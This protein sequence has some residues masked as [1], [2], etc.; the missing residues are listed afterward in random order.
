MSVPLL[1]AVNRYHTLFPRLP[2]PH[3][4]IGSVASKVAPLVTM[5]LE[6]GVVPM[7]TALAHASLN[8]GAP[9][10]VGV[11]VAVMVGVA[12]GGA[13]VNVAVGGPGVN[14]RVGSGVRV[15]VPVGGAGLNVDV[16]VAVGPAPW[17]VRRN[18]R[19]PPLL[20]YAEIRK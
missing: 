9:G 8:C 18:V 17:K 11:R 3:P 13:A 4:G 1:G 20:L 7:L 15:H 12:V 19:E 2:L 16:G 14:V 10:F 5:L 6:Y